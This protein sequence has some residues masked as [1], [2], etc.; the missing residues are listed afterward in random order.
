MS[1]EQQ[2]APSTGPAAE[3]GK[4]TM[5][6]PDDAPLATAPGSEPEPQRFGAA[7]DVPPPPADAPREVPELAEEAHLTQERPYEPHS[8]EAQP[9]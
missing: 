7:A 3:A 8:T 5:R 6:S 9:K 4:R 1:S 2:Q